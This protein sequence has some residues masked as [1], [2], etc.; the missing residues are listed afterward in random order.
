MS[1]KRGRCAIYYVLVVHLALLSLLLILFDEQGLYNATGDAIFPNG[2]D[3]CGYVEGSQQ[4][5]VATPSTAILHF[6]LKGLSADGSSAHY[7]YQTLSS[8]YDDT[9]S[10][11]LAFREIQFSFETMEDVEEHSKVVAGIVQK[12]HRYALF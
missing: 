6:V 3:I 8:Y 9:R 2:I 12:L 4:A 7:A 1:G 10:G 11:T 5:R